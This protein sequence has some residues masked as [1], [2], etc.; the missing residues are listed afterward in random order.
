[1]SAYCHTHYGGILTAA[2]RWPEADVALTDAVRLWTRS[3]RTLRSG[4]LVRLADLRVKQGRYEEAERLLEGLHDDEAVCPRAALHLARGENAVALDLLEHAVQKADRESSSCVP[5]LALLVDAQLA[6]DEDPAETVAALDGCAAAHPSAYASA[7]AAHARG[8]AG[9]DDP[10]P[11]LRAAIDGFTEAQL[12]WEASRCRLDL[13]RATRD[14]GR[15]VAIAHARAALDTFDRLHAARD[16]DAASALLR[17]LG[18]KVAAPQRT[19]QVLSAREAEVL[20]LLGEGLSN[21]EISVRLYISRKTVEHHVGNILAKLGLR[22]R[23]EAAAY[24]VRQAAGDG[25][26]ERTTR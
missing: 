24:A 14:T 2:G 21:P 8:R 20:G 7:V 19:G 1:V 13:A 25:P 26:R 18:Q 22:N 17:Q 10:K 3:R 15:E 9:P 6:C 23:A 4:A 16:A 5:V 12:P 11:W